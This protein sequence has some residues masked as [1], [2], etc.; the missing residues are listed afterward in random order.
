VH[1]PG[2]TGPELTDGVVRLRPL[3]ADDAAEWLAGEDEELIRGFESPRPS[4]R[5]DV[6]R[7][8]EGWTESWRTSGPVR[9]WAICD[10][11]GSSILGGVELRRLDG[12]DVN[13]DVNL[14]YVVFPPARRRGIATRAARLAL[15]HAAAEMGARAAV[16]KVLEGNL[17]S[18]GV[19]RRLGAVEVG[20]TPSDA[21][22]TFV[23]FRLELTGAATGPENRTTRAGRVAQ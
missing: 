22:G 1:D 12:P 3:T 23:V 21:G 6:I 15:D 20:R 10:I 18:L 14:S 11:A 16:I 19:A 4:T 2:V 7:A 8:I 9:H 13:P 17:A 5:E